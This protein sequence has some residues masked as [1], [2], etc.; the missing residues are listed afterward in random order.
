MNRKTGSNVVGNDARGDILMHKHCEKRIG[1]VLDVRITD[2]D[3][4]SYQS[5]S[6]KKVL[7]RVAKEKMDKYVEPCLVRHQY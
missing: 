4:N 2:M 1:S 7:E 5:S 3:T 6:S